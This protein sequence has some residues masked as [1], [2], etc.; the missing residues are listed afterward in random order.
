MFLKFF[1]SGENLLK[2]SLF[3]VL[4]VSVLSL[5]IYADI[6]YKVRSIYES[7][8]K[9]YHIGKSYEYKIKAELDQYYSILDLLSVS[10]S[11]NFR[12]A[13]FN[14]KSK[15]LLQ[16]MIEKHERI[17]AVGL[18][19]R[20][21]DDYEN[22]DLLNLSDSAANS[23]LFFNRIKE[24]V[25]EQNNADEFQGLQ[26]KVEVEKT[27]AKAQTSIL[28]PLTKKIAGEEVS[29]IPIV[30]PV[31]KSKELVGYLILYVSIDWLGNDE[32]LGDG[33]TSE[34]EA[35][36]TVGNGQL[37]AIKKNKVF[38][39]ENI[40]KVCLP[41]NDLLNEK[42]S[43]F[44]S[45]IQ[46]RYITLCIPMDFKFGIQNWNVCLRS[47]KNTF[48]YAGQNRIFTWILGLLLLIIG[49]IVI[50]FLLRRNS[51]PWDYIHELVNDIITGEKKTGKKEIDIYDSNFGELKNSLLL[52]DNS[53][54]ELSSINKS[55]LSEDY[56]KT[57][58][59][60][61]FKNKIID[62]SVSLISKLKL[63][64]E[65]YKQSELAAKE[66]NHYIEGL[67]KIN[68][69]LK[70]HHEDI[71]E[72]SEQIIRTLVDLMD[73]EMGAVFLLK[74][75][76]D[77]IIL[78][79]EV[80][81]AYD[82]NKYHKRAFKIGESLIGSCASEKR[83]VHL[84]K[85]PE[86]YLKIISG[87][88]HTSP[89]S[90]LIIPLIFEKEVLGVIELG[91]LN[92]FDQNAVSFAEKAAET[93][94][95]T[96]SLAENNIKNSFLL[97]KTQLQTKE[98]EESDRKMKEALAEL[99]D[100]QS[101][102]AKS[103]AEVRAKLDAMNN[104]L[105]MV[106]YTTEGILLDANYKFL[107]TMQYS[108]EEIKGN[109]VIEL[110]KEE[111]RDELLKVINTV[112]NGN[113]YESVMR[114]HTKLGVE[115]WF[116]ATYTPVFNDEGSVQNILFFGIDITKMRNNELELKEQSERLMAEIK[117]LKK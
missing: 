63:A 10:F 115:K 97:E 3:T 64:S 45:S 2:F 7:E 28:S 61:K 77:E 20:T 82:E 34:Y 86:D 41:C 83:T 4:I 1:K 22:A 90:L 33:F 19:T 14:Q 67:D 30:S 69:V 87:L 62:S 21:T 103:E 40:N 94:A 89:K 71:H 112:K 80:S 9:L 18:V 109:N 66:A 53:L 37:V 98:L 12:D 93:I 91:T 68:S 79:L 48:A 5:L 92:E 74:N 15:V 75:E 56:S 31:Y 110:L 78:D 25:S 60:S 29:V 8:Q 17:M 51:K 36:V 88:G 85:I 72:L 27:I 58:S 102:T 114:R 99:K 55:A 46:D 100:I 108:L 104:T 95:N 6:A 24:G 43:I 113:Y 84:K 54:N 49:I 73:V 47:E 52:I 44:N 32:L 50:E 39:A 116:M 23:T 96:L 35:F 81:Y 76:A 59:K 65:Q 13:N 38:L 70:V 42:G 11:N 111:D 117:K 106:E 16:N 26:F 101:K 105:M 107:N 57:F